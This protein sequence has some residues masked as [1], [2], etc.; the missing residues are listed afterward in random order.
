M[1]KRKS[2]R[3]DAASRGDKTAAPASPPAAPARNLLDYLTVRRIVVVIVLCQVV[4]FSVLAFKPNLRARNLN[5]LA[6]RAMNQGNW[7][8]AA[9][10]FE[11]MVKKSPNSAPMRLNLAECRLE[12]DE[13]AEALEH[14]DVAIENRK[15]L[16]QSETWKKRLAEGLAMRGKALIQL[17]QTEKALESLRDAIGVDPEQP[18]A[19][20][21]LGRFYLENNDV[22]AAANCIRHLDGVPKFAQEF[23]TLT[24]EIRDR[25]VRVD[26]AELE[27]LPERV[28]SSSLATASASAPATASAPAATPA[29]AATSGE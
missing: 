17:D 28:S 5:A 14:F 24:G 21:L 9:R 2:S 3:S 11:R 7:G 19:N 29:P 16:E 23:E 13:P 6:T 27:D 15:Q 26:E 12:M 25:I 22:I 4:L 18:L 1:A 10:C 8:A 20:L